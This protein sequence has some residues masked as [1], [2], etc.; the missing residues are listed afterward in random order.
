MLIVEI[1]ALMKTS[2][3]IS[4]PAIQAFL[5]DSNWH[6]P[7][8]GKYKGR[9]LHRVFD[10]KRRSATDPDKVKCS[11]SEALGVYGMLRFYLE[12]TVGDVGD[13]RKPLASF[14][15]LCRVLD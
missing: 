5:K 4:R 11:C 9:A 12:T 3:L 13:L 7:A 8:E 6:F 2:S 15:A 14:R 1:E 10:E